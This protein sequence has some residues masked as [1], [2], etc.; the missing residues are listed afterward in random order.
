[1]SDTKHSFVVGGVGNGTPLS[2]PLALS[3][4]IQKKTQGMQ[5][6]LA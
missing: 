4:E 1:M 2:K 6:H 5:A 3:K